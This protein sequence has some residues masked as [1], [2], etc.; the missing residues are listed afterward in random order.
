MYAWC[1]VADCMGGAYRSV[2]QARNIDVQDHGGFRGLGIYG[3]HDRG[4]NIV[5]YNKYNR[6]RVWDG[7]RWFDSVAEKDRFHNELVPMA[8]LGLISDLECQPQIHMTLARIG[9]KP[10]FYYIE[11]GRPVYEDVKGVETAVF[12]IKQ[13]LWR[14]YGPGLL[15]ITK[16]AGRNRGFVKVKEIMP[17]CLDTK[18]S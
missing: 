2:Q 13:R 18:K 9:Y 1:R 5:T 12:K 14:Y 7:A 15:R 4:G 10:D 17:K 11:D 8:K 3:C 6:K 16:R